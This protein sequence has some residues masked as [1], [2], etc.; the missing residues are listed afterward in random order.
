M[1]LE[2]S[3]HSIIVCFFLA[4]TSIAEDSMQFMADFVYQYFSHET[5]GIINCIFQFKFLASLPPSFS[6]LLLSFLPSMTFIK[7]LLWHEVDAGDLK[8]NQTQEPLIYGEGKH[9]QH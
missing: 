5:N 2:T 8:M 6:S 7:C 9:K 3:S 1:I 4:V